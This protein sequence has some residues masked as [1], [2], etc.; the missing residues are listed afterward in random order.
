MTGVQTCALPISRDH[1]RLVHRE[2]DEE[3]GGLGRFKPGGGHEGV[4]A[5]V[6]NFLNLTI[7]LME[8]P[9]NDW[10]VLLYALKTTGKKAMTGN[11]SNYYCS[12]VLH[13]TY[14][15]PYLMP[16]FEDM[17]GPQNI[18]LIGSKMGSFFK[19]AFSDGLHKR[20][21]LTAAFSLY[22]AMH[23]DKNSGRAATPGSR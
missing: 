19:A 16:H 4:A 12:M 11:A 23:F 10:R 18:R 8:K 20:D 5:D 15:Y 17:L 2:G 22:Y 13:L 1:G 6:S 3:L 7:G 14:I 21:Y 9:G